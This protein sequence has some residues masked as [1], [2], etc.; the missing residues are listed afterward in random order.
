MLINSTIPV[1]HEVPIAALYSAHHQLSVCISRHCACMIVYDNL[2]KKKMKVQV[3]NNLH[4]FDVKDEE[5]H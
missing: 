5:Y 3:T 2:Q 4:K 1:H